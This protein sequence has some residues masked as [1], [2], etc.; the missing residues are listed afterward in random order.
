MGM[1]G[2]L[3]FILFYFDFL[4]GDVERGQTHD[5][6]ARESGFIL[7]RSFYYLFSFLF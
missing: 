3:I 2:P 5:K 6:N 1:S 7:V 4:F